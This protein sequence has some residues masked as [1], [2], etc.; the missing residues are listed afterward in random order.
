[1]K[2]VEKTVFI[3]YRRTNFYTALAV[4][5]DLTAHGYDVFFDYQSIDSGDFEQVIFENIKH[6]AHF[7]IILS[8][9]ALERLKD[10]KTIMRREVEMAL[11]EKRN[12]IPLMMETFDFGS[13]MTKEALRG[14]LTHLSD[15]NGL[16]L[17]SDYFFEG[18]ENLRKRYLSVALED[19][20]MPELS[21]EIKEDTKEKQSKVS[22]EPTVKEEALTAEEWLEQRVKSQE[23]VNLDEAI[24]YYFKPLPKLYP[25]FS[26][27][28]NTV[29]FNPLKQTDGK[30][31]HK[32]AVF[33]SQKW[34]E[35]L[36]EK[37]NNDERYA[38]TAEKSEANVLLHLTSDDRLNE[39]ILLY[40]DLWH[41]KCRQA[42]VLNEIGDK[43]PDFILK[44]VYGDFIRILQGELDP[45]NAMFT[46]KLVVKGSIAKIIVNTPAVLE[47][48]R[49]VVEMTSD[50]I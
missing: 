46:G 6:R 45:R 44:S 9:S 12:I 34:L 31:K 26:S 19:V 30:R 32:S 48:T 2:R 15:Y 36:K 11:D 13:P 7:L 1:M 35:V 28:P 39:E 20:L 42:I 22:K 5:Q 8:P 18:M 25:F 38:R 21:A 50:V 4:Y 16:R 10:P 41:G 37:L 27:Y 29:L 3:S 23:Q 24:R 14:K 49:C 40:V 17:I 33:P 47:F 43:K